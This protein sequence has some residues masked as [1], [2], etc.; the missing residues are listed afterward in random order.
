MVITI[1]VIGM[2]VLAPL[3][4]FGVMRRQEA[5]REEQATRPP[6]AATEEVVP[7][8]PTLTP[9][10]D[11]PLEEE[12]PERP[13]LPVEEGLLASLYEETNPSV[14]NIQVYGMT[15]QGAGS[16]FVL[17][18]DGHIVTNNHVVAQAQEVTAIFYE[19][20]EV[21]AE[22]IGTDEDSD[23]AVIKVDAL[24]EGVRPLAL[25]DSDSVRPGDW[26]VAIG[27]PF[28]LGGSMSLGIVSAVGRSIPS[29]VTPFSIPQAIQTDAAIN[30]G[31][32]GGPLVNLE[33]QVIGV[34]AQIA[35]GTGANAGV[36]FAIPANVVRLVAPALIEDGFYQWPWLGVTGGSVSLLL[37]EANDLPVQQGAYIS[38]VTEGGPADQGGIQGAAGETRLQGLRVPVGGDVVIAADGEEITDFN[39]LLA[40]VAFKRPGD[41]VELT[42][43]RDGERQQVTVE[44]GVRP[45]E[46]TP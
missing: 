4:L 24:P 13:S 35:S 18:D 46:F 6:A 2:L 29:G 40:Y 31:N 16:G 12:T 20:P 23:L 17:D 26:V 28:R 3:G 21:Q 7:L 39:D 44:L 1:V 10:P 8:A 11:E 42:I 15:G 30:P 37:Q 38:E 33:G 32:S 36:G 43:L 14:V 34:N 22:I 27:N 41:T 25:G 9:A 45:E 5:V 19:G